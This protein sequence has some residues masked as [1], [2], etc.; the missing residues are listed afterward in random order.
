MQQR[1]RR[2]RHR[3]LDLE[4]DDL[5]EAALAQL[6]LD[7]H[8]QVGRLFLLDREVGVARDPEEVVLEDLHAREQRVE[9]GGDD[10]L[11]QDVRPLRR[12]P[13]RRGS[14]GGTLMRAKRRSPVSGSRTVTASDSDRSLMYGNG[15]AGSTASGVSTGKISSKNRWRSSTLALRPLLVADDADLLLRQLV[16]D[17]RRT[18]REW[19][20][21][22]GSSRVA[23]RVERLRRR[24]CRPASGWSGRP[25]P[26]A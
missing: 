18:S 14:T 19:R 23:D 20:A 8:Q 3:A 21:T 22:I 1:A 2:V 6:L 7:R 4:P 11:E 9:V 16:A 12:P 10:L 17:A 15:C 25:R 26:A 13:I 24:S 5:A